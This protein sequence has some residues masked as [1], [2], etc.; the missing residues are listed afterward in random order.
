MSSN[1]IPRTK[2]ARV[3]QLVEAPGLDPAQC[4]FDSLLAYQGELTELGN[5]AWLLTRGYGKLYEG[6][7]PS[8]SAMEGQ[9]NSWRW[10]LF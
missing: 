1:L 6:S 5:G 9:A 8:L 3:A 10:H 7:I 4:G 2:Y